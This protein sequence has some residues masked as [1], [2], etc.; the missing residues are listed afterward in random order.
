MHLWLPVPWPVHHL[1]DEDGEHDVILMMFGW[2]MHSFSLIRRRCVCEWMLGMDQLSFCS[3][4]RQSD[5][6]TIPAAPSC[7][8]DFSLPASLSLI[9]VIRVRLL[10]ATASVC[11]P[12][13]A[14]AADAVA[15][16]DT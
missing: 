4:L 13:R 5:P 8:S 1:H 12:R 11:T 16:D 10:P 7:L 9:R 6:T 2:K 14:V 3:Q 15:P